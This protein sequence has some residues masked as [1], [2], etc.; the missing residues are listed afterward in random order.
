MYGSSQSLANER[1]KDGK[2]SRAAL[3]LPDLPL[4]HRS[5]SEYVDQL[6]A[7]IASYYGYNAFLAEKLFLLF[8]VNEVSIFLFSLKIHTLRLCS[9]HRILRSK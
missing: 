4:L 9:G 7:D 1:R 8:P 2:Y 5:R 6:V 3:L